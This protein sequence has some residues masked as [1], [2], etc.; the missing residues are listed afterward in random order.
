MLQF[1]IGSRTVR[2]KRV[3]IPAR[4]FIGLSEENHAEL[5]ALVT[6]HFGRLTGGQRP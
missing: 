3:T 6:D 4:P 5:E 1:K 2:A